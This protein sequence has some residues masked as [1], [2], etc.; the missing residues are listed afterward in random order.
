MP[1]SFASVDGE[2]TTIVALVVVLRVAAATVVVVLVALRDYRLT[3]TTLR[4]HA[5][6]RLL[7][8]LRRR[9]TIIADYNIILIHKLKIF[10]H[11]QFFKFLKISSNQSISNINI[12]FLVVVGAVVATFAV[13]AVVTA[14]T[15][16]CCYRR[17][18]WHPC[19]APKVVLRISLYYSD[20][21]IEAGGC[22]AGFIDIL[23]SPIII[24][25]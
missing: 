13:I 11:N 17:H 18:R 8:L 22:D 15:C 5:H 7:Y 10:N 16:C 20:R 12:I 14:A 9:R 23:S 21:G 4:R 3:H 19:A 6:R 24:L 25:L 2:A 1:S